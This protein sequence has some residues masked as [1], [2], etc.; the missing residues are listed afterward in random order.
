MMSLVVVIGA[1]VL[2]YVYIKTNRQARVR[3]LNKVALPGRWMLETTDEV[4]HQTTSSVVFSG[5][6]SSG[7]FRS[8][9]VFEFEHGLWEVQG[10][11]LVLNPAGRP[12]FAEFELHLFKPGQIGIEK[13][14]GTRLLLSKQANNVVALRPTNKPDAG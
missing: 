2:A 6:A 3:W 10:H 8:Q 4:A 9:G 5:N 13:Q 11:T 1:A 14:D 7:S 12:D